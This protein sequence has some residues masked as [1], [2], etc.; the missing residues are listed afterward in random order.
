MT[1]STVKRL[2]KPLDEPEREFQRLRRAVW[3]QHQNESLA[4]ARRNLFDDEASFSNNTKTKPPT[5]LKTLREY[6]RPNS[7]G[8]RN[9]ITLSTAQTGRIIDAR[10]ILLIQGT[11]TFIG[12]RN[13]DL[14][15][16]IK[17]YLSIVDSIQAGVATRDTSRLLFFHFSLK[18]KAAECTVKRLTKPLDE[19]EREFQRLRRAV[20]RQHQNESLAIARRNLF[21]DEASFSNNTRTKPPTPLKTLREYSRPN[22]SGFRNPITLSTAQTGRIIDARDILLIQGT[23][24]FIGLRNED[25]LHQIKHYLS[26]VDS[27]QAGVATRDTSRLLFFHFSL[28]RKAAEWSKFEYEL[29][30]FMLEKK[31]YTKKIGEML[32]QHRKK[33]HEQFSQIL[34]KIGESKTPKPKAP[35]FAITN[36]SGVSTRDPPFL[37]PSEPTPAN[38]E[39]VVKKEGPEGAELS[40]THDEELAF[41]P[42]IFYQPF[43]SLNLLFPFR[44]KKKKKDDEDERLL[45][46]FKHIHINLP[47]LEAMIY[48]PKGAK[49]SVPKR[50]RP[51][52]LHTAMSYRTTGSQERLS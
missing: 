25:L 36:R 21:D 10:D 51:R 5:P 34:S 6:S 18:R 32:D 1:C 7:S 16:Q 26:I 41:W 11:C 42:S 2:T 45:S 24:T 17:H 9:P 29:A 46:I 27:I 37:T 35:T 48:I 52:K 23:C 22:S 43:K 31:S 33:M 13:E 39:G 20:W 19:P 40:I 44:V 8:F 50:R 38:T 47:F 15:H 4:I 49:E 12:L 14:L 30:N 3:R 28:K